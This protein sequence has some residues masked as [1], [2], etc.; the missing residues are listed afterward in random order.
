MATASEMRRYRPTE[1]QYKG[2]ADEMYVTYDREQKTRGNGRALYHKVKRVYIAGKI[3]SWKTGTF[4]KRTGRVVYGV[5][6]DYEQSRAG[7]RR[8]AFQAERN[9]TSYEVGPTKVKAVSQKF[10]KIVEVPKSARNVGF[11][12]GASMLPERYRSALQRVR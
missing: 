11:Y 4:K 9:G 5:A 7:Y 3:K 6:I 2:G 10:R 1:S 8:K 12:Q